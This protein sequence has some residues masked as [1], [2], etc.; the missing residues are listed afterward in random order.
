MMQTGNKLSKVP[1]GY[2]KT[3]MA[4]RVKTNVIH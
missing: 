1:E 4:V 2:E 3:H